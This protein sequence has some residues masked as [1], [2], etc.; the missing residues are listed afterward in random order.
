M[1]T[2]KEIHEG[3]LK[4]PTTYESL[5]TEEDIQNL[6]DV[7]KSVNKFKKGIRA[8]L[9]SGLDKSSESTNTAMVQFLLFT[10]VSK[11]FFESV[12]ALG[13]ISTLE[14]D[15]IENNLKEANMSAK[16]FIANEMLDV[17]LHDEDFVKYV[18][19]QSKNRK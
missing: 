17:I 11:R 13:G 12:Y 4:R 8:S 19:E 1:T 15:E 2:N 6:S 16:E 3:N 5:L 10:K 9:L 14:K 7:I 18:E